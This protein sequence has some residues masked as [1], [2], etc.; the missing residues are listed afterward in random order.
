MGLPHRICYISIYLDIKE[1]S[2]VT[3]ILKR[4]SCVVIANW[5]KFLLCNVQSRCLRL[6]PGEDRS[7]AGEPLS[8]GGFSST[9]AMTKCHD[10]LYGYL[11]HNMEIYWWFTQQIW[12]LNM[13]FHGEC[14]SVEFY[15]QYC[16]IYCYH[17]CLNFHGKFMM[18]KIMAT[19]GTPW[20]PHFQQSIWGTNCKR[21]PGEKN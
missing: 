9:A 20:A 21:I 11:W 14:G 6:F 2:M 12:G 8:L 17:E 4:N 16:Y 10:K 7:R 5:T 19:L 1:F 13:I 3:I 18:A 15:T